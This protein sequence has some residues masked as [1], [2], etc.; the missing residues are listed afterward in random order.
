MASMRKD[1]IE[2]TAAVAGA[3]LDAGSAITWAIAQQLLFKI[4][5]M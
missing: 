4:R 2:M 1:E 3:K 5:I